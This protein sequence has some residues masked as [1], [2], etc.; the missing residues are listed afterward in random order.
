[1]IDIDTFIFP[2]VKNVQAKSIADQIES[3]EP[4]TLE[5]V[6]RGR[7][8]RQLHKRY[9][10]FTTIGALKHFINKK[11]KETG[12]QKKDLTVGRAYESLILND[13]PNFYYHDKLG[14]ISISALTFKDQMDD[15]P[16]G[17]TLF[18]LNPRTWS[19]TAVQSIIDQIINGDETAS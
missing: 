14:S 12:W 9:D 3:V 19:I 4:L 8:V 11:L 1:M 16:T 10:D 15:L 2:I 18:E 7:E 13:D 17:G 5:D 6:S